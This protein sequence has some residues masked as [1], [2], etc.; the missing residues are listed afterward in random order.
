MAGR[1]LFRRWAWEK[2]WLLLPVWENHWPLCYILEHDKVK[3]EENE[4]QE[5]PSLCVLCCTAM[6]TKELPPISPSDHYRSF[7]KNSKILSHIP[8]D[9]GT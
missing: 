2:R 8:S 6:E 4:V 7:Q 5:D 3:H 9:L 1:N